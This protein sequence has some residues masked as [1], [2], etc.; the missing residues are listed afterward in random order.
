[1]LIP[2]TSN[3]KID[4]MTPSTTNPVLSSEPVSKNIISTEYNR[5]CCFDSHQHI[6]SLGLSVIFI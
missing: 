4:A 1:M 6:S 3:I 5:G 2:I